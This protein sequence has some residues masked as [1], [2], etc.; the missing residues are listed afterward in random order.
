MHQGKD[1]TNLFVHLYSVTALSCQG[2]CGLN[3]SSVRVLG[4]IKFV[5]KYRRK[6]QTKIGE[7]KIG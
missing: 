4:K 1:L 7:G 6:V 2:Q 3:Y 5:I